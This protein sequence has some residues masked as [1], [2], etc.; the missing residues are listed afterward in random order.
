M[1]YGADGFSHFLYLFHEFG[2][3]LFWYSQ[4]LIQ[5]VSQSTGAPQGG[6]CW[7]GPAFKQSRHFI[8]CREINTKLRLPPRLNVENKR[9]WRR[10]LFGRGSA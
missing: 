4:E 2:A 8:N 10:T 9:S 1:A 5:N 3:R 7:S 6:F